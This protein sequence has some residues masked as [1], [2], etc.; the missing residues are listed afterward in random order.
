MFENKMVRPFFAQYTTDN[1]A[2][3]NSVD[4][5]DLSGSVIA[6]QALQAIADLNPHLVLVG[7]D[8]EYDAIVDMVLANTPSPSERQSDPLNR[9]AAKSW[10][11][12]DDKLIRRDLL[13]RA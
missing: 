13:Q 12:H 8:Q 7:R 6:Q 5:N 1:A 2:C 11:R 3:C 10:Q 4:Q 9:S